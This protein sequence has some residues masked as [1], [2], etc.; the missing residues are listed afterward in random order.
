[1]HVVEFAPR[2]MALQLDEA[3]G[4]VLRKR[5]EELGV[6]VHTV[7]VD[8]RS[9]R[10]DGRARVLRFADGGELEVDAV[11]F[12]AGIRP[13]DELAR[14]AGLTVGERGGIVVDQ[15]CRTSDR[16]IYAIGECASYEGRTL[17][18]GRARLPDGARRGRGPHAA[19][20]PCSPAST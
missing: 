17:R 1:M 20:T 4:A 12:S 6:A 14:A 3:G 13:R 19:A 16:D 7:D 5:I 9:S 2:L 10:A 8:Q 18:P 11:V 15:R